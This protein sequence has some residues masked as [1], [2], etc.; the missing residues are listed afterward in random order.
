[1]SKI[2]LG[3]LLFF[4]VGIACISNIF[5][6]LLIFIEIFLLI[7]HHRIFRK[8]FGYKEEKYSEF[9][10]GTLGTYL[11][12]L[13]RATERLNFVQPSILALGFPM[14]R[15]SAVDGK[16]LLQKE[17]E[18]ITDLKTYKLLFRM[19]PEAGTI[20]CSLS[21]EKAW[22][23]FLE[24]RYEFAVIFEDDVQ[25][26]P[27]ELSETIK[28]VTKKK[29][30]W[31]I[32]NFETKHRGCP[33]KISEL[34]SWRHLVVYLFSVTHAGCYLIN[35]RAAQELLK[36]FYPIKMPLDHYFT[37]AWEFD[38]KF[39]GVEP[40]MVQQ[41]FGDSQIKT[42]DNRKK[43]NPMVLMLGAIC[44]FQRALHHFSYNFCCWCRC[45]IGI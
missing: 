1:M 5:L 39:V 44:S 37:S 20:G 42:S 35:R 31:D 24:S 7:F 21:H 23:K 10:P 40:R 30:L 38:L 29:S 25:F 27:R 8:S 13:D 33:V 12:N 17:I 28:L 16:G 14:E 36:K 3:G 41:K 4:F 43:R 9:S 26:D 11:I 2:A 15:I 45:K 19:S 34:S 22:L 6:R 18:S 32:A